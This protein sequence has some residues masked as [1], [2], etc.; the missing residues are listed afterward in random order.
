MLA[1]LLRA[2]A[3]ADQIVVSLGE[4]GP[5][6]DLIEAS[7]TEVVALGMRRRL[8]LHRGLASLV[9]LIRRRDAQLVQGWL[10]H[11]NLAAT[12]AH[13]F[14]GG[15]R[16]LM[17][18]IRQSLSDVALEKRA[19]RTVIRL[20]AALSGRP[21]FIV[22]NSNAGARQHEA[23]GYRPDRTR[24]VPN[25]FDLERFSPSAERR[26]AIRAALGIAPDEVVVGLIGRYHPTKNHKGFL[27]AATL[28]L[29]AD[30][31]VRFLCAGSSVTFDNPEL[32]RL[33]ADDRLRQRLLLLGNRSDVPDLNRALDIACN[34]SV[35]EGFS[36]AVGEAM[37]CGVP[38][39]A[40][41]SGDSRA[42]IANTGLISGSHAPTSIAA[43][44]LDLVHA[45][46]ERRRELGLAARKRMEA[47]FSLESMVRRYEELYDEAVSALG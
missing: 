5:V 12:L 17:W 47:C 27:E 13:R 40:T 37:A 11:G 21:R 22:Y 45:G 20:N 26:E 44:I 4:R 6:G 7:G 15:R 23:I 31:R 9:R 32:A 2:P 43:A 38:C 41:D 39:V 36:N 33:T 18:N 30:P 29:A 42:V 10:A 25:G 16:S 46:A 14:A 19:T 34:V 3:A 35:G 8:G 24:I 1:R 28:V